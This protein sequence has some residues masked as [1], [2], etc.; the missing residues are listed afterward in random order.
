MAAT[1]LD[2]LRQALGATRGMRIARARPV[3]EGKQLDIEFVDRTAYRFHVEWMKDSIAGDVTSDFSHKSAQDV[4]GAKTC[5]AVDAKPMQNGSKLVVQF[6]CGDTSMVGTSMSEEYVSTW[7]HAF[8][9]YVGQPL[10]SNYSRPPWLAE[11]SS[12]CGLAGGGI[13]E[14]GCS[15]GGRRHALPSSPLFKRP[16]GLRQLWQPWG[17]ELEI[18]MFDSSVLA[19][20]KAAQIDFLEKLGNHGVALIKG[21]EPPESLEGDAAAAPLRRLLGNVVGRPGELLLPGHGRNGSDH[22]HH[23]V[24][25]AHHDYS[26]DNGYLQFVYQAQGS[27]RSTVCDGLALADYFC[28]HHAE[29]FRLL[30]T[31][32]LVHSHEGISTVIELNASGSLEKVVQPD[33]KLSLCALPY[34]MFERFM[35]AHRLWATLAERPR[36]ACGFAWP[37]HS[38][39]VTN[40]WR[41][42]HGPVVTAGATERAVCVGYVTKSTYEN[43]YRLLRQKKKSEKHRV[44]NGRDLTSLFPRRCPLLIR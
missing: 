22:D 15:G 23:I 17:A 29:E 6:Q 27:A 39:L 8:A 33:A 43:R 9:P 16:G 36:F 41:V 44:V 13:A 28:K 34:D 42:L 32:P 11:G 1:G 19:C 12:G 20:D 18:P 40:R 21:V 26:P 37:E 4:A 38:V 14:R 7:L 10:H 30:T 3:N 31:T 24:M 5:V 2:P 35:E 25:A